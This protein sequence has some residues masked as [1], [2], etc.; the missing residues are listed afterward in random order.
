MDMIA[1]KRD[2][3]TLRDL[4]STG[5]PAWIEAIDIV[6]PDAVTLDE[7]I[8]AGA[9][10]PELASVVNVAVAHATAGPDADTVG[11][12][13]SQ[14]AV[15]HDPPGAIDGVNRARLRSGGELLGR[16]VDDRHIGGGTFE[17]KRSD[18]HF[19]PSVSRVVA[20]INLATVIIYVEFAA[21]Q[22][23]LARH[24]GQRPVVDEQCIWVI[25][26][27]RGWHAVAVLAA[28]LEVGAHYPRT[29][30]APETG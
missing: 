27:R 5:L 30:L 29:F 15:F 1:A 16:D 2:S 19:D 9:S 6:R 18:C 23:A 4:D 12:V 21:C 22:D 14:L 20:E 17:R 8:V 7:N 13:Q 26:K 28:A 24:S 11:A 10:D 25:A 3:V